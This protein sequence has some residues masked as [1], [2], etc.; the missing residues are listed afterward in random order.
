MK[1]KRTTRRTR[2]FRFFVL[3][4]TVSDR[5]RALHL[6]RSVLN[7]LHGVVAGCIDVCSF[8]DASFSAPP[9]PGR[10]ASTDAV[11]VATSGDSSLC[12]DILSLVRRACRARQRRRMAVIGL[13]KVS[14][15]NPV[16]L[17]LK[18]ISRAGGA[19]FFSPNA[20]RCGARVAQNGIGALAGHAIAD[21]VEIRFTPD[22]RFQLAL[23][24]SARTSPTR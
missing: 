10:A 1:T 16:C 15:P 23:R 14:C 17:Q 6:C 7:N 19:D 13:F 11:V 4:E 24:H 22:R 18:T 2:R 3:Y 20:P 12:P 9:A 5:Q 21:T 8:A